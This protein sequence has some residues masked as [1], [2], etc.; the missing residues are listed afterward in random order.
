MVR[1]SFSQLLFRQGHGFICYFISSCA[2]TGYLV[3]QLVLFSKQCIRL[4]TFGYDISLQHRPACHDFQNMCIVIRE[5][6]CRTLS[7]NNVDLKLHCC[8]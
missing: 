5:S 4:T 1:T 6:L 3:K 7:S 2:E 8:A